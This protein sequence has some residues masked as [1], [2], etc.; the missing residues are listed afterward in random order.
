VIISS[1]LVSYLKRRH[2]KKKLNYIENRLSK[3]FSFKAILSS[4]YNNLKS[5]ENSE[6][7][8]AH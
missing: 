7:A 3:Y 8:I 1:I 4:F 2:I 5:D 6:N